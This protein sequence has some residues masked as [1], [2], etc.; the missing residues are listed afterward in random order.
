VEGSL[1]TERSLHV[2][3][4][5]AL[6]AAFAGDLPR[7][8]VERPK[9]SFPLPFTEWVEDQSAALRRS[10]FAREAFTMAAIE[11]VASQPGKCWQ[12]AWPMMNI[13]LWGERWWA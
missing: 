11:T 12:L 7:E 6:R 3:T 8:V 10:R 9:A 2:Q 5:R 13:A 4:K 1:R